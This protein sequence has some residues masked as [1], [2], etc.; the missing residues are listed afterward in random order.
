[1]ANCNNDNA[2]ISQTD[3]QNN[4][5]IQSQTNDSA[6]KIPPL[7]I[8]NITKFSQFRL[9][10]SESCSIR[11]RLVC[12]KSGSVSKVGYFRSPVIEF[13]KDQQHGFVLQ[14]RR[15]LFDPRRNWSPF[16]GP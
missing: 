12:S 3:N 8:A 5:N 2:H 4:Y 14:T 11:T 16:H 9:E 1:M 10:L 13:S 15:H 7:F 6:P